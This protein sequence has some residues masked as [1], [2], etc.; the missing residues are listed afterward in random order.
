MEGIHVRVRGSTDETVEL[1]LGKNPGLKAT[2]ALLV[3]DSVLSW[4]AL[5][6]DGAELPPH[7]GCSG[8]AW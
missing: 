1:T 5:A 8:S 3:G 4:R 6:K 2:V 7:R